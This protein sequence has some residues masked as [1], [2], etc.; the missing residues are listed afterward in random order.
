MSDFN[1]AMADADELRRLVEQVLPQQIEANWPP[2][3]PPEEPMDADRAVD[4]IARH[5]VAFA[6]LPAWEMYPDISEHHWGRI[7]RRAAELLVPTSYADEVA[8]AYESLA[9]ADRE[10]DTNPPEGG[11]TDEQRLFLRYPKHS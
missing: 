8:R 9:L 4:I 11:L 3:E 1:E 10:D 2:P 5:M 6:T 7:E